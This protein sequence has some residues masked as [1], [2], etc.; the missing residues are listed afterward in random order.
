MRSRCRSD[1]AQCAAH[2]GQQIGDRKRFYQA[3]IFVEST[4]VRT[5]GSDT[6][7]RTNTV[8]GT[9]SGRFCCSHG[10][11]C[12]LDH[13]PGILLSS[14][15]MSKSSFLKSPPLPHL[16]QTVTTCKPAALRTSRSKSST[17]SSSSTSRILPSSR[18]PAAPQCVHA[19]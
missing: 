12:S 13:V 3:D 1:S 15:R 17:A 6:S 19:P 16:K 18:D 11:T 8:L 9:S 2:H 5:L 10:N 14:S 7:E 4:K